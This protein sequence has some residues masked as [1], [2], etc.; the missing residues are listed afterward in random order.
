MYATVFTPLSRRL[1]DAIALTQQHWF[2]RSYAAASHAAAFFGRS[3]SQPTSRCSIHAVAFMM[4]LVHRCKCAVALAGTL[5]RWKRTTRSAF[6]NAEHDAGGQEPARAGAGR[7]G[8]GTIFE[9]GCFGWGGGALDVS[10]Y[11]Q[12][13]CVTAE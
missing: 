12:K 8:R 3:I 6:S 13:G 1:I 9:E 11:H 4:P 2:R 7:R 10:T 5:C